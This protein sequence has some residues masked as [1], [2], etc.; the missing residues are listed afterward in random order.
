MT[1]LRTVLG[2]AASA[3]LLGASPAIAEESEEAL[4]PPENSAV[5]QYTEAVPTARGHKDVN[6]DGGRPKPAK[7][8][9][10][11]N[12]RK[13]DDRGPVG[14]ATAEVAAET[15]P[16]AEEQPSRATE[17][18]DSEGA[19]GAGGGRGDGGGS[20]GGGA[21]AREPVGTQPDGGPSPTPAEASDVNGS[22]GLG[23]ILR[24]ATGSTSSGEMG[25]LLPLLILG[26]L[27]WSVAYAL[28]RRRHGAH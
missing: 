3:F 11:R 6:G 12:A 17:E 18:G 5:N 8:L 1:P 26:A 24:Q 7:V 2:L 28:G 10:S 27:A 16:V 13:L 15:A 9:G 19:A 22:S 20:D 14:R 23:E 21:G 25:L 4:I